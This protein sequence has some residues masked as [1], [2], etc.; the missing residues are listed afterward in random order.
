MG[1]GKFK[2]NV[3]LNIL[4]KRKK[5]I[6]IQNKMLNLLYFDVWNSL[7]NLRGYMFIFTNK[8]LFTFDWYQCVLIFFVLVETI[9]PE[10]S[11]YG[12][13]YVTAHKGACRA[14]AF[15]PSGQLVATGS[16]DASI[17]VPFNVF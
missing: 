10:A 12:T 7:V 13:C 5:A 16:E 17:K 15:Q 14:G 11:Q 4:S 2:I 3:S 1:W 8:I 6:V 9:S